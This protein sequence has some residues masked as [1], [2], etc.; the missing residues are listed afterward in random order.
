MKSLFK[1]YVWLQ[2][3]LSIL[4]LFGG[5]LIIAF[6]ATNKQNILEDALNIIAAVILF[7]FGLFAI[8]TSFIFEPNKIFTNGLL[9]GSA[10]IALGV[11]LC[12]RELVLLNYLVY[13]LAIFFIVVGSIELI[14][15]ILLVIKKDKNIPYIIVSFVAAVVFITGGILA[16]VFRGDVKIAFCIIAGALLFVAGVYELIF[17]I[18]EIVA[19]NKNKEKKPRKVKKKEEPKQ[20]EIKE[21]DY[22]KND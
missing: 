15:G 16:L 8:L 3:I 6:A 7:L 2:L 21:L 13:L 22:T 19:Q 18:R 17:G 4:L 14:N 9:Y 10:C 1:K 12:T 20:E 5:A 11:F